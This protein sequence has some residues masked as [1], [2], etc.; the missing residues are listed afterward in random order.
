MTRR[1]SSYSRSR[2]QNYNDSRG[3]YDRGQSYG[4]NKSYAEER[5]ERLTWFFLVL[6]IAGVQIVQQGGLALP[7]WV[8]PFAGC[9]VLLG[10][11]V[12]QYSKRWRVAPTTWLAGALLAGMALINLYV[13]PNSSFLGISLVVFAAVILMGLLTGET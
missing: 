8:I 7:N 5:V 3:S 13:S 9:V 1:R 6:A 11:G 2:S 4:R 12:Y 10:S